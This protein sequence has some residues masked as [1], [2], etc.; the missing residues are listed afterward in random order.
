MKAIL[1][2]VTRLLH[3]ITLAVILVG[4]AGFLVGL[5][6][7][8][9]RQDAAIVAPTVDVAEANHIA[10]LA[11]TLDRRETEISELR[12]EVAN[13][14]AQLYRVQDE[15]T[16]LR[17]APTE[18]LAPP[19]PPPDDDAESRIAGLES[20]LAESTAELNALQGEVV[21]LSG[22]LA[23]AIQ[24]RDG[25]RRQNDRARRDGENERLALEKTVADLRGELEATQERLRSR[26]PV[27]VARDESPPVTAPAEVAP[28]A[29]EP[30]PVEPA[31]AAAPPEA[32]P[33]TETPAA[34]TPPPPLTAETSEPETQNAALPAN[35]G[36]ITRGIAAYQAADYSKAYE[37]WLPPALNGSSR[38]QFYVGAL[39]F[40]GRGVSKDLVISYMW[41]RAA[42]KTDD[43]G[44]IKLL[45]R[46]R[47]GMTGP[48]LAEAETRI[49]NGETIPDR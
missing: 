17:A 35:A 31:V 12:A 49:A 39:Y 37:H 4:V 45:D 19:P 30:V 32:T 46:V 36:P 33:P 3:P 27:A 47:E 34:A 25:L 2:R 29:P 44:A 14:I 7:A 21:G 26:P 16:Q 41:L 5:I 48:E 43:P 15:L 6:V 11:A 23:E 13:R 1:Y 20:A 28:A 40:E 38:A 24:S 10:L 42:T 22:K 9:D 18:P 8:V